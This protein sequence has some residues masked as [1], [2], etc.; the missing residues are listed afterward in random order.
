M[1]G[2]SC[3]ASLFYPLSR[4]FLNGDNVLN[5]VG[6][7]SPFFQKCTDESVSSWAAIIPPVYHKLSQSEYKIV[8]KP[9]F[10]GS[11]HDRTTLGNWLVHVT[12][13]TAFQNPMA[14]DMTVYISK[15]F[16]DGQSA[17]AQLV[18]MFALLW[19]YMDM[20]Q[21]K[22]YSHGFLFRSLQENGSQ[23]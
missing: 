17:V 4:S 2:C 20:C 6:F 3:L 16:A 15:N 1:H 11:G 5:T 13:E 22:F 21:S 23:C 14:S 9:V 8:Q 10:G 7:R 18:P 12:L 19:L